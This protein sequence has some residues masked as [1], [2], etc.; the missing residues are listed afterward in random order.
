[1]KSRNKA[2]VIPFFQKII[3]EPEALGIVMGKYVAFL[4]GINVGGNVVIMKEG[5]QKAFEL[6]GLQNVK[7]LLNSGNVIFET[8]E[9]DV[10]ALSLKIRE[11]LKKTFCFEIEVMLR[12]GS[13]IRSLISSDPFKNIT[14]TPNTRLYIT[15]LSGEPISSLKIPYVSP[16]GDFQILHAEDGAI[17][18]VLMLS[19][20]RGTF[21]L[22]KIMEKEFGKKATTRNW[23]TVMKI[24][25]MLGS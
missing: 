23:N 20:K 17:F 24:A 15:F 5:L 12:T 21:D 1:M 7:I 18:S 25:K 11:V 8:S 13:Q 16:E 14:V 9:V 19:P 22:M 6:Q 10:V 2:L 4:R 3:R